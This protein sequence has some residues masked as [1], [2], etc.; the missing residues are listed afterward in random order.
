MTQD[1]WKG[2]WALLLYPLWGV[3]SSALLLNSSLFHDGQIQRGL[4]GVVFAG[5]LPVGLHIYEV[6][7]GETR[8]EWSTV[9][10]SLSLGGVLTLFLGSILQAILLWCGIHSI[11]GLRIDSWYWKFPDWIYGSNP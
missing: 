6:L 1:M 7:S 4:V 10:V 3:L 2:I 11:L 5:L 9:F 8:F